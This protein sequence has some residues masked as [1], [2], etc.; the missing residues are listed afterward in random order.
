MSF[1][2]VLQLTFFVHLITPALVMLDYVIFTKKGNLK[3]ELLI[4]WRMYLL[5]VEVSQKYVELI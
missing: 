3:T 2:L 5:P 4:L 1:L